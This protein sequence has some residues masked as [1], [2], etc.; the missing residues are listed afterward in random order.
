MDF[1]NWNNHK[2]I[3][4]LTGAGI[5][6]ESGIRTFRDS[7]GLWENHEIEDVATPE[8][9]ERDPKLV[10]RFYS[11]RRTFAAKA[12]PNLA[13]KTIDEFAEKFPGLV[14]LVTQ[15]V[16]TLHERARNPRYLDPLCMHGSLEK[17]RCTTCE[18]IYLDDMVWLPKDDSTA[19]SS[20]LL[21]SVDKASPLSLSQYSVKTNDNGLPLSP[22]CNQLLRPH[23][24]WF[25]EVP[26]FMER[27]WNELGKCDLFVSIGTS[28]VVYP[29]AAFIEQAKSHGA[30]TVCLNLEPIPQNTHIDH[31]VQGPATKVVREF[32]DLK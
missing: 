24:V 21:T 9:F 6:A 25:G 5:S 14:T 18:T 13:H 16:D 29:A 22:C 8:A 20:E 30:T 2:H 23:I 3:V 1:S 10:W 12:L 26:F 11:M 15:N 27:I 17:S 4:I 28:G 32:F 19:F 7:N 31:F